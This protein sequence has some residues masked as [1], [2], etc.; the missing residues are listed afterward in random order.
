MANPPGITNSIRTATAANTRKAAKVVA[1]ATVV[2]RLF[3]GVTMVMQLIKPLTEP[4]L[5]PFVTVLVV[6]VIVVV[7]LP[8]VA[9]SLDTGVTGC[10]GRGRHD[11]GAFDDL[12]EFASVQPDAATLGAVVNLDTLPFGHDKVGFRAYRIFHLVP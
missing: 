8:V 3:T 5:S 7:V 1:P 9:V 10:C 2:R 4:Q 6:I 12:V 11:H